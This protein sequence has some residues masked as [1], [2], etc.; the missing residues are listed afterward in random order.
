MTRHDDRTRLRVAEITN[1][2]GMAIAAPRTDRDK[3]L[4]RPEITNWGTYHFRAS[5]SLKNQALYIGEVM[6]E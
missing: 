2:I 6:Y 3:L 1:W 5:G 4:K